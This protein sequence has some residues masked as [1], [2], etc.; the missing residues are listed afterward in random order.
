M[1][2]IGKYGNYNYFFILKRALLIF[3]F[4]L[5]MAVFV[6]GVKEGLQLVLPLENRFNSLLVLLS[7]V[8]IGVGIY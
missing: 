6:V 3:I 5:I 8:G 4:T 1:W 7:S 2:A